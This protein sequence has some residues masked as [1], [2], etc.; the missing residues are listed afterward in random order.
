MFSSVP[1]DRRATSSTFAWAAARDL[2][3]EGRE[4]EEDKEREWDEIKGGK[5]GI[6]IEERVVLE[7][8]KELKLELELEEEESL[9][10]FS[11]NSPSLSLPS[12]ICLNW[13]V[14]VMTSNVWYIS[15]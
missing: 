3:T 12:S 6:E 11:F 7:V 1:C 13:D 8:E 4:R 10:S 15:G 14:S 5:L 2:G 9:S